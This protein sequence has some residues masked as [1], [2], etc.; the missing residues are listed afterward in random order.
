MKHRRIVGALAAVGM[1]LSLAGC[2]LAQPE[3]EGLERDEL[4]G[5]Y[6]IYGTQEE[7]NDIVDG[8]WEEYGSQALD[9]GE[10]GSIQTPR[11]ILAAEE[12]QTGEYVFPGL[13]GLGFFFPNFTYRDYGEEDGYKTV[14]LDKSQLDMTQSSMNTN[15]AGGTSYAWAGKA[16]Y[17]KPADG[18]DWGVW[19][20]LTVYQREDGMIYLTDSGNSYAGQGDGFGF[21]NEIWERT[22]ENGKGTQQNSL[23][24]TVDFLPIPRPDSVTLRQY[25][26]DHALLMEYTLTAQEALALEDSWTV[27]MAEGTAYTLMVTDN[28]DGTQDFQLFPEHLD[29]KLSWETTVWFLDEEGMG[30]PVAVELE[31]AKT[32]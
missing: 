9:L 7:I 15:D 29:E 31:A 11:M 21:G 16:Y 13:K 27:P 17:G 22:Q 12:T 30:V 3:P 23:S 14:R 25:S 19:R 6:L 5:Y 4:I 20:A 8:H 1:I 32:N 24:F 18:G 2:S 10:L 28:A 26:G